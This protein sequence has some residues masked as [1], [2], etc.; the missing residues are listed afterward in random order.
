MPRT[1]T[2]RRCWNCE[3]PSESTVSVMLG[4]GPRGSAPITL[5]KRCY[6][7]CLV[8]LLSG[9][10]PAHREPE[11]QPTVLVVDDDPGVCGL[12]M[13][14]LEVNGF[15]VDIATN[16]KEA[17]CKL[18]TMSPDAIVL[19]LWMPVMNGPDFLRALRQTGP[20]QSV[21]VLAI[22]AHGACAAVSKLGVEAFLPKPFDVDALI[23][24]V[25]DLIASPS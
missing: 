8:P 5:C 13:T 1:S 22:S 21:P 15:A 10:P 23:G 25:S 12:V 4:S 11:A 24:T 6:T 18:H 2:L 16:G 17:L 7:D 3:T 20:G 19:D 9:E 14:A